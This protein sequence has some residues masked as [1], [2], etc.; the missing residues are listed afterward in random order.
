MRLPPEPSD[1]QLRIAYRRA[2]SLAEHFAT[3]AAT[4][5]EEDVAAPSPEEV[6]AAH[7]TASDPRT[8]TELR[9]AALAVLAADA[10]AHEP[11]ATPDERSAAREDVDAAW[12]WF[13]GRRASIERVA[14]NA[15]FSALAYAAE[16]QQAD[17]DGPPLSE[18]EA[19][20]VA[21]EQFETSWPDYRG[22]V[23]GDTFTNAVR[24]WIRH[25]SSPHGA[26]RA[27]HVTT[28]LAELGIRGNAQTAHRYVTAV[29][30]ALQ[31]WDK[32]KKK[33]NA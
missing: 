5:A 31:R 3:L 23:S 22:R 4:L 32:E 20:T 2:R 14:E 16:L 28:V 27:V 12:Q 13:R 17:P 1:P 6:A 26:K 9:R 25:A 15:V 10:A 29:E 11:N 33:R 24:A 8:T 7:A 30:R 19:V 21:R 18:I